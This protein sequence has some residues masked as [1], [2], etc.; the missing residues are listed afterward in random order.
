MTQAKNGDKVT[1]HYTGKLVDGCIFDTTVGEDPLVFTLGEGE[2]ID[3]FEEGVLSM[4]VGEKKTVTLEP[5]KAYGERYEDMVFEVPRSEI[6][7]D[8]ELEIGD[9][10]EFND[11]EDE[12]VLATVCQLNEETV[13]FDGN[14]PLAGETLIFELELIKIG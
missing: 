9:E 6:P 10:L 3:G 7:D 1:V 5:E 2:L 13:T 8:L 11:E 4:R 14:A 12:P